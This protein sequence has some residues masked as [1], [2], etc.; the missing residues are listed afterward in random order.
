MR[1]AGALRQR[2]AR[3]L[4]AVASVAPRRLARTRDSSVDISESCCVASTGL[5]LAD[6]QVGLGAE[7]GDLGL[8]FLHPLRKI[9]DLRLSQSVASAFETSLASRWTER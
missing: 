4:L 1:R 2:L 7:V 5:F 3:R 9:G 8:R 6:Q